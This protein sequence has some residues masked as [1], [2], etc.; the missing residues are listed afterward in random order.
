MSCC[1]T[2]VE[3]MSLIQREADQLGGRGDAVVQ[4]TQEK[5]NILKLVCFQRSLKSHCSLHLVYVCV[6][7]HACTR[8]VE[9]GFQ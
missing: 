6:R 1:M 9:K 2:K 4:L 7:V 5:N 3:R 8:V